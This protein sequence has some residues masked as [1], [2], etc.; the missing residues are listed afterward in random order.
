MRRSCKAWLEEMAKR[1]GHAAICLLSDFEGTDH[2]VELTRKHYLDMMNLSV[3]PEIEDAIVTLSIEQPA[4]G[5]VRVA[6]LSLA[7]PGG[8]G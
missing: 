7:P 3:P 1:F 6:W 8:E 5:Q 4:F 2:R